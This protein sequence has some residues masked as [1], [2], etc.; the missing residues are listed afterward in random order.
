MACR[1]KSGADEAQHCC[2][3]KDARMIF[4]P[5]TSSTGMTSTRSLRLK[6]TARMA[7]SIALVEVAG[8]ILGSHGAEDPLEPAGL[9]Q[10]AGP[11]A[12]GSE[13]GQDQ[14][15][16]GYDAFKAGLAH[17]FGDACRAEGALAA[18]APD[19]DAARV[20]HQ[21]PDVAP[22]QGEADRVEGQL[23][24]G[25]DDRTGDSGPGLPMA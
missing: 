1:E 21:Q 8:Q 14:A 2:H 13:L 9:A 3:Q 19:V 17:L 6:V 5:R 15:A 18:R 23:V 7:S 24:V 4:Q 22:G 12:V 25:G 11:H 20:G 10:V 16:V